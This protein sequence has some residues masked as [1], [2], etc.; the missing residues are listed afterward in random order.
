MATII[1]ITYIIKHLQIYPKAQ[2]LNILILGIPLK[3][4]ARKPQKTPCNLY[5]HIFCI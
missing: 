2:C 4:V 5:V 1:A 3:K